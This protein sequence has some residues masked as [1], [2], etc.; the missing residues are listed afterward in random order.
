[1]NKTQQARKERLLPHSI[2]RYVRVYDNGGLD[3]EGGSFDRFTVVYSG[4]YRSIGRKRG[5]RINSWFQYVGMSES[6]FNP[7]GFGQHSEHP[8]L[9]DVDKWGFPPAMGRKNHLGTRIP[10]NSLPEDCQKLVLEDYKE[11]WEIK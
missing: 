10:F 6:P 3:V 11:L 2:P 4:N 8:T 7:Q 9:I 5:E 1:M